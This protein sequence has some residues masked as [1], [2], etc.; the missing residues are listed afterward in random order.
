VR[1]CCDTGVCALHLAEGD[2][3]F[4]TL[5]AEPHSLIL[6]PN[7]GDQAIVG[8]FGRALIERRCA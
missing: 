6:V 5:V 7:R 1:A 8:A 2:A 3:D 4:S